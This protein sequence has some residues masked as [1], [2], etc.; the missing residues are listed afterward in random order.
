MIS[1]LEKLTTNHQMGWAHGPRERAW[2]PISSE[3]SGRY[4]K[5]IDLSI[6]MYARTSVCVCAC[7]YTVI[8][9]I[10]S[11]YEKLYTTRQ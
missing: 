8:Q 5:S 10:K 6:Y 1:N 3:R 11:I 9:K 7:I 2:M 4:N